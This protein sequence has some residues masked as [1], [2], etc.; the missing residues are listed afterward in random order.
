MFSNKSFIDTVSLGM[1]AVQAVL[2][3][4]VLMSEG[5]IEQSSI[6]PSLML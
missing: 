3:L 2:L 4:T 6:L 1:L 5:K